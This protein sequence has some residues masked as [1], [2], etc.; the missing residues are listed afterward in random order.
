MSMQIYVDQLWCKVSSE[1]ADELY[2]IVFRGD[3]VP[4]FAS[5]VR[6]SS[7]AKLIVPGAPTIT[8]SPWTD[9]DDG[10]KRDADVPIAHFHPT[11]IRSSSLRSSKKTATG[12]SRGRTWIL[13]GCRRIRYGRGRCWHNSPLVLAL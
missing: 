13:G 9:L 11:S 10:E 12:T 4:P 2:V 7:T 3:T 6:V 1:A 5:A 8:Y